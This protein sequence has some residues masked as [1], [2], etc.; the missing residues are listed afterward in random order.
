MRAK[1]EQLA[2][3]LLSKKVKL[4]TVESC[5][6]GTLSGLCTDLVGSSNWFEGGIVTY[7]NEFKQTF[8]KVDK[9]LLKQYGAVSKP[10]A[11]AMAEGALLEFPKSISV[12]ITGIA[13]PGGASEDKPVG[14]VYIAVASAPQSGLKSASLKS[15]S[16]VRQ[17]DFSGDRQEVRQQSCATAIQMLLQY[18]L[19]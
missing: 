16:Q 12:A 11:I 5:T 17:C 1:I 7:S 10:V 8:V 6:G 13:G 2:E 9:A 18:L 19:K 4:I 14:R 3:Q 15:S